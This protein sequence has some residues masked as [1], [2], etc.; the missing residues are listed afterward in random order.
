MKLRK[1]ILK[2]IIVVLVI[3]LPASAL[4]ITANDDVTTRGTSG[5]N[6]NNT[7]VFGLLV[8]GTVDFGWIEFTF[9]DVEAMDASLELY[10]YWADT[11]A[12]DVR[13][14]AAAFEFDETLL[15][16]ANKPDTTA[17][18]IV[19]DPFAVTDAGNFSLD[20]TGFYNAHLGDI[21]TF[22][23]EG[24]AGGSGD[25]PIFVD[26]E[27]TNGQDPALGPRLDVAPI[28]EPS[29]LLLMSFG[30]AL[31]AMQRRTK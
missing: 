17:W 1:A 13:V 18:Q 6:Y 8:K 15:T 4:T 22:K 27:G 29:C 3:N 16:G 24:L 25:G 14:R 7:S 5:T 20:V 19:V 28:P 26:R 9:G 2:F 21:V 30:A 31:L 10:N 12:L 11:G 23:L